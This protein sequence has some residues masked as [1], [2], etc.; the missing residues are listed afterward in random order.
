M[1]VLHVSHAWSEGG[2]GLYADA[3]VNECGRQG[4]ASERFG[5]ADV[6]A[7]RGRGFTTSFSNAAAEAAF[8][9]CLRGV[10]L[11][12]FHHLS[13]LSMALPTLA[14]AA[15]AAVVV[16]L[17]DYWLR[18]ARGQLMNLVDKRCPGPSER[19]CA[20]CLA[21]HLWAPLP[22]PVANR[23]PPRPAPVAARELAWT[24]IVAS[25]AVFLTPSAHAARRMG[26]AAE[27]TPL[28]LLRSVPPA[29]AP[30]PGPVRFLFLGSWIPTKGPDVALDAF[31]SL[32]AGA[33]TL[34][35]VGPSPPWRGSTAWSEALRTRAQSTPGVSA[36]GAVPHA[37]V[38][39]ELHDADVL[40][41]PSTWEETG[42]LVA[43]E[44]QAAGLRVLASD[45]GGLAEVAPTARRVEPGSAPAWRRAMIEEIRRG[46]GR[47]APVKRASM[48]EHAA[49]MVGRY[50]RVL[51]G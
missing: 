39:A 50:R 10:D 21:P 7:G 19:R 8:T 23:L 12:H 37:A 2:S 13:G 30:P 16:T 35:M 48:A 20:A 51:V 15:G 49:E 38:I 3:L 47:V 45:L 36:P 29:P 34:R 46:R 28:P 31:A 25:T 5:P 11:V 18:C 14:R 33:A 22:A 4:V 6:P 42:S 43:N 32:P 9:A 1:R 41:V 24:S 17:H 26:V 40:L 27:I 44:A